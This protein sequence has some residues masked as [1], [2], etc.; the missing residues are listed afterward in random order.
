MNALQLTIINN[1]YCKSLTAPPGCREKSVYSCGRKLT[2]YVSVAFSH[3]DVCF[4][5]IFESKARLN[6]FVLI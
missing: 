3:K 2:N 1:V 6:T 4:T 5:T